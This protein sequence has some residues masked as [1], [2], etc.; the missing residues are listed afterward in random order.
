MIDI[1]IV[2]RFQGLYGKVWHLRYAEMAILSILKVSM[3]KKHSSACALCKAEIALKL[4][5]M[6]EK[7]TSEREGGF[8]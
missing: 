5:V 8:N 1:M 2:N 3:F 7:I 4:K 6:T